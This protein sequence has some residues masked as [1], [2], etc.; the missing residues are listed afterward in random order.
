MAD[1]FDLLERPEP[2]PE[3]PSVHAESMNFFK[4]L[5]VLVRG[6]KPEVGQVWTYAT[7]PGEAGSRIVVLK[8]E[9]ETSFGTI[10]H[11]AIRGVCIRRSAG[12]E[13]TEL[14]HIPISRAAF[15]RSV[16][17]VES[18]LDRLPDFAEGYNIWRTAFDAGQ[19]GVFSVAI[20]EIVDVMDEALRGDAG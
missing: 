16:L 6:A 13:V 12:A 7:R 8:I 1:P 3:L 19:A 14:P 9:D 2:E 4:K 18:R 10:V 17:S 15:E 5:R 11:I 20:A